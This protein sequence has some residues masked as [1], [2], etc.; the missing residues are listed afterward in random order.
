VTSEATSDPAADR[1]SAAARLKTIACLGGVSLERGVPVEEIHDY[2]REA[3]NVVWVDV[4]D[5]GPAELSILEEE[6]GFHPLALESV[7]QGLPRPRLDEYKAY[8][9]LVTCAAIPGGST[10]ELWTAGVN[11]FIGRN[12]VVSI[13]RGFVPALEGAAARWT[14]GGP[15]LRDG[16]GFLVYTVLD[17]LMDSYVPLIQEIENE[18][19]ETEIAMLG[20]SDDQGVRRLL[21]LKR[22]LAELRRVV[23]PLREIFQLLLRRDNPFFLTNSE[24]Y[25]R[26]VSN[27]VLQI[28]DVL[29]TE[30]EMAAGALE[31]SLTVSSNR[32]NKTMKTLAVITVSVAVVAS[33]FGAY[34]MNFEVIPLA[35]APWGFWVVSVGTIAS[36]VVAVLLGRARGWW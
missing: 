14:R 16:V 8:L 3:D 11:L 6:F 12:Y 7:T 5:P 26:D 36:V 33:V 9:L 18:I 19:G 31:A 29:E 1:T 17:A 10:R 34:G 15:R 30:R 25:L 4:R 27:R 28:L 21:R 23:Y 32:L 20:I 2:I 24:V 13:H 22:T 35:T